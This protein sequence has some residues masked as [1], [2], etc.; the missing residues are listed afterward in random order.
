MITLIDLSKISNILSVIVDRKWEPGIGDPTPIGWLTVCAYLAAAILC[1]CC[2]RK[3][4]I[5]VRKYALD[6]ED[7]D[8][9]FTW[10]QRPDGLHWLWF[11]LGFVLIILALNKQLDLQTWFTVTARNLAI[12]GG[13]YRGRRTYQLVFI[14]AVAS[15][16][17]VA[18]TMLA[19]A[20]RNYWDRVWL[21]IV[22]LG[23]LG[24]FIIIRAASFHHVDAL[25]GLTLGGIR[26]NAFLELGGI[27]CITLCTLKY[28]RWL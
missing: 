27:S 15:A 13:W 5:P 12:S 24:T 11:G 22:G 25:L 26:L 20:I 23:L 16:M 6:D 19:I 8:I 7:S 14:I 4:A 2:A 10:R 21:A 18:V 1:I 28:L 3:A 17:F 9:E